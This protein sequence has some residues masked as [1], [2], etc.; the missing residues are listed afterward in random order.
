LKNSPLYEYDGKQT[1]FTV[2]KTNSGPC[3]EELGNYG[4]V[5]RV[6]VSSPRGEEEEENE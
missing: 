4:I 3:Y 1:I 6:C 5:L 2:K